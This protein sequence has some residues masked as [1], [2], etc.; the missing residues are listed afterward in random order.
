MI[1]DSLYGIYK[2]LLLT[3]L[4]ILSVPF[5]LVILV[6]CLLLAILFFAIT[7]LLFVSGVIYTALTNID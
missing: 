1:R 7:T 4:F 2:W 5:G 3:L 6:A